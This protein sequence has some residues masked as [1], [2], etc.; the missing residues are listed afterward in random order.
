MV[1]Q[2]PAKLKSLTHCTLT[3]NIKFYRF[4]NTEINS[5]DYNTY[6]RMA[7]IW[8]GVFFNFLEEETRGFFSFSSSASDGSSVEFIGFRNV[9]LHSDFNG[10]RF[11]VIAR[12]F[13]NIFVLPHWFWF[14]RWQGVLIGWD[15]Q[16]LNFFCFL[17]LPK[18]KYLESL[19]LWYNFVFLI[20]YKLRN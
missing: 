9:F 15:Q 6:S 10:F 13:V 2:I 16:Q 7:S 18:T 17:L 8:S 14:I 1:N 5:R 19:S 4:V 3:I 12:I 20:Y 11:K